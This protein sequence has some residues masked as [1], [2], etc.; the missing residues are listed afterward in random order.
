MRAG[1]AARAADPRRG[2][3]AVAVGSDTRRS[4]LSL[5]RSLPPPDV[6]RM[7]VM[8]IPRLPALVVLALAA[9]TS[10]LPSAA[11]A[12]DKPS[13]Q[14]LYEDG[15]KGRYLMDG[16][17]LFRLDPGNQGIKQRL[18]RSASTAG[19]TPVS[20]PNAWNVGDASNASMEG[21]IGWYRK[22][23]ELP[24]AS[25][26]LAWVVRFE[27]VNSRARVWLN[28]R[29]VGAHSGAY[30]PFELALNRVKRRGVNRLVVRVDSRRLPE[31]LPPLSRT[32]D[33]TAGGG[34]WNWSGILREV[35]LRKVQRVDWGQ[36]NVRPH[37]QC[38]TCNATVS[39]DVTMRNVTARGQRVALTGTFGGKRFSLGAKGIGGH[40]VA[41]FSRT[42]KGNRPQLWSPTS[43]YLYTVR[44]PAST[45][46]RYLVHT[47][48]RSVK[49]VGDRLYL[50]G[51]PINA[52]GF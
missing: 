28:A 44:L 15:P 34:W 20:V 6:L 25:S 46:A 14:T 2:P 39:V 22:D 16:R 13:N 8:R 49:K 23:F 33:G 47:G 51:A 24:S 40:G 48:I 10:A 50:N 42:L 21:G 19:W 36:V 17:W 45:G 7:P 27:T 37:L 3:A 5:G 30:P 12:A 31:D 29:P 41:A 4:G 26:A 32:A 52:R 9:C 18:M 35:Y 1:A 43:P 38:R 11:A